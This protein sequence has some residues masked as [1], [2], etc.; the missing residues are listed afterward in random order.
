LDPKNWEGAACLGW[1]PQP[2][3]LQTGDG[4]AA[5]PSLEGEREGKGKREASSYCTI[6]CG[7][8]TLKSQF[9]DLKKK[10]FQKF[11]HKM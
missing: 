5:V 4:T 6:T 11:A 3:A 7:R 10:L 9:S 8:S 1:H 2:S